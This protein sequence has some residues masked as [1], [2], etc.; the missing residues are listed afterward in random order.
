[1]EAGEP[2][3]ETLFEDMKFD[4]AMNAVG[5]SALHDDPEMEADHRRFL[6]MAA[7]IQEC[8]R[9][10]KE[11]ASW[12]HRTKNS[13]AQAAALVKA[14]F[15]AY[16]TLLDDEAFSPKEPTLT[17]K[18][19]LQVRQEKAAQIIVAHALHTFTRAEGKA[20]VKAELMQNSRICLQGAGQVHPSEVVWGWQ[21]LG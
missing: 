21:H 15:D 20:K 5:P 13:Q 2:E 7:L 9:I 3:P 8:A 12:V 17:Q 6:R 10:T 18:S 4:E 1:M 19:D 11:T 14:S 16:N